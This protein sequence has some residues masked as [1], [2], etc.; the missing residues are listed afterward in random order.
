V[1]RTRRRRYYVDPAAR[2]RSLLAVLLVLCAAAFIW[3]TL[4][5]WPVQN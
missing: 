3:L 1:A 4:L 2:L 5:V